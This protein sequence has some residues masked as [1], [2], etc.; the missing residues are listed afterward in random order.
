MFRRLFGVARTTTT[1]SV[2]RRPYSHSHGYKRWTSSTRFYQRPGFWKFAGFSGGLLL[3]VNVKYRETIPFSGRS[4]VVVVSPTFEQHLGDQMIQQIKRQ[5]AN[6]VLPPDHRLV[7]LVKRVAERLI[8]ANQL[9]HVAWEFVVVDAPIPNAFVTP[10][11]KVCVFKGLL[12]VLQTEDQLAAVLAHEMGHALARHVGERITRSVVAMFLSMV[13]FA[14][15]GLATTSDL[16]TTLLFQLPHSRKVESEAD[17]IGLHLM[18]NACV[19]L[20]ASPAVFRLLAQH[21]HAHKKGD[22][23]GF[24][25][26]H[27]SHHQRIEDLEKWIPDIRNQ[28]RSRCQKKIIE[29]NL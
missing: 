22:V 24:L 8:A 19:P 11:G 18:G 7:R 3:F 9:Q 5:Y 17:L 10:G 2:L 21:E 6:R 27:P 16:L 1:N 26:T 12:S 29:L 4:H 20:E 13:L 28:Y 25:S 14:A 23:P 15:T